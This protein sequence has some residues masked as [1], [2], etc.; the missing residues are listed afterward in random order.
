MIVDVTALQHHRGAAIV[1]RN[2]TCA[3]K[4]EVVFT[5]SDARIVGDIQSVI[6]QAVD[7]YNNRRSEFPSLDIATDQVVLYF[8]QYNHVTRR[9]KIIFGYI[10]DWI[11]DGGGEYLSS[12]L[13]SGMLDLVVGIH[14]KSFVDSRIF[15]LL[16]TTAV[17]LRI[18]C[19]PDQWEWIKGVKNPFIKRVYL[20]PSI[21]TNKPMKINILATLLSQLPALEEVVFEKG[22]EI[23]GRALVDLP[24]VN[25][26]IIN[27]Q[28]R[29]VQFASHK[30]KF[31]G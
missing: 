16:Q 20:V 2:H 13:H 25:Y 21:W 27:D 10:R 17:R 14:D 1:F 22:S 19:D 3:V 6:I 5:S 29:R 18:D 4:Y 11:S 23:T 8:S 26:S 9:T 12:P 28:G 30:R 7:N 24:I 15:C 31:S